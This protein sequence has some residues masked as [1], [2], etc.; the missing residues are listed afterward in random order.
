MGSAT[1]PPTPIIRPNNSASSNKNKKKKKCSSSIIMT[2][3]SDNN[4]N[5]EDRGYRIPSKSCFGGLCRIPQRPHQ[6]FFAIIRYP[7]LV[8]F[9]PLAI[10]FSFLYDYINGQGPSSFL[11]KGVDNTNATPYELFFPLLFVEFRIVFVPLKVV[12]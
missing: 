3:V 2:T 12:L 9:A 1:P 10:L 7:G 5:E 6:P 8:V 11:D 4:E